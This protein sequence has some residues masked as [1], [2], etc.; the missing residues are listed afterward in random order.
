MALRTRLLNLLRSDRITSEIER[1]LEF[2]LAER[3]EELIARGMSPGEARREARRRLGNET[4]LVERT[5]AIDLVGWLESLLTDV[6][7]ALRGLRAQ[8]GFAAVVLLT[9][10]L[11]IGANSAIFSVVDAALLRPLPFAS[12]ER[13]VHVWETHLGDVH[14]RS[15]ASYPDFIDFRERTRTFSALEGYNGTNVIWSGSGEARMLR[16]VRVTAGLLTLLGVQPR[17]GRNF[18]AGEDGPDGS[19]VVIVSDDLWRRE[20]GSDPKILG[21]K[22][23]LNAAPFTVIGVLPS[24]FR[25]AAAGD[26]EFW[27]PLDG[28]VGRRAERGNHWVNVVGRLA[29]GSTLAQAQADLSA[30]MRG[31]AAEYPESNSGRDIAVVPAREQAVGEMRPIFLL[32]IGAVGVVL[33]IACANVAGLLLARGL[34]R[35]HEMAVRAAL[36]AG[37]SRLLRQLLTETAVLA[38][39]GAV[40]GTWLGRIGLRALLRG[41][42][43][44]TYDQ[45]PY[46]RD[47]VLDSRAV[48]FTIAV[49]L[50]S[51]L[52]MGIFPAL[53]AAGV[54]AQTL[55]RSS[56]RHT[57]RMRLREA[58]VSAEIALTVVL[59]LGAGLL[60]R[61]LAE[62][63]RVDAGFRTDN[64]V[65]GRVALYGTRYQSDGAQQ[66]LFEDVIARL[67]AVPGV[68]TVGAVSDLPLGGGGTNTFRVERGPEPDPSRR[69]EALRRAVAGDY[70]RAL[71]IPL[72]AG[73]PFT[74]RDDSAGQPSIMI[75][76]SLARKLFGERSAIGERL[77]FYAFPDTAF[78]IIGVVGDVKTQRLDEPA[79]PTIYFTHLQAAENRMSVVIH[80]SLEPGAVAQA[81]RR[82]VYALDPEATVYAVRPFEELVA[83]TPALYARRYPL[84]A[85]GAFGIVAF[86][87]AVIGIYGVIAFTVRQRAQEFGIRMA[88]GAR[89]GQV[90]LLVLR[91][92]ARIALPGIILGLAAGAAL[93]RFVEVLLFG[94]NAFDPAVYSAVAA[95]TALTVLAASGIP[96]QRTARVDP[97]RTLRGE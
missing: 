50:G 8:P 40:L 87:L 33:L 76:Q 88:L 67:R 25:F 61:S 74:A 15:E 19:P 53:S 84:F 75:N 92:G 24:G 59:L 9:L 36:G 49:T 64:V 72:V 46:L 71:R 96:A 54:S 56:G 27:V 7:Y 48:G 95:T 90:K 10:T 45:M 37:R 39:M 62:L 42:P 73:R 5:R 85:L 21:R 30:V 28:S 3:T 91:Q 55:L 60:A 69:P 20:L 12:P 17:L 44:T 58:L 66:R 93:A 31:L 63:V 22:L 26:A 13:L 78:E 82:E 81:M 32:L 57:A 47:V 18:A 52:L 97:A 80:S 23:I 43:D 83:Q 2:H 29:N 65:T 79:P 77:R 14:S 38:G 51:A 11:G 16:G 86:L 34:A 70:F 94:V 68:A 89:I 4:R 35:R 41:L 6:R 1:E